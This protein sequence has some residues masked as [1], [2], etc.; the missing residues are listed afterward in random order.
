V[1]LTNFVLYRHFDG[2][3]RLLYVGKS[4]CGIARLHKHKNSSSWFR[5]IRVVTLEHFETD[6]AV[7]VAEKDAIKTE[8]PLYNRAHNATPMSDRPMQPN[9]L[10]APLSAREQEVL[11]LMSEGLNATR[12]GEKLGLSIKTVSTFKSRIVHKMGM[13]KAGDVS[14]VTKA[15]AFGLCR[16]QVSL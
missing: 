13:A 16:A 2:E 5:D 10:L 14:I 4:Q 12:I 11:L 3:G 1:P 8:S 6:I 15:R 7:S 9:G